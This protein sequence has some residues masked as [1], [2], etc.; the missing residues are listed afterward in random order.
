MTVG[1]MSCWWTNW[2]CLGSTNSF[3]LFCWGYSAYIW[4]IMFYQHGNWDNNPT[5]TNISK[6]YWLFCVL[7][8]ISWNNKPRWVD[9]INLDDKHPSPART[10]V[11]LLLLRLPLFGTTPLGHSQGSMSIIVD[12]DALVASSPT[13]IHWEKS[14]FLLGRISFTVKQ[15]NK[16]GMALSFSNSSSE[17][18]ASM[19]A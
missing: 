18:A 6:C 12:V 14:T 9:G 19:A 5:F 1:A 7:F 15:R 10:I 17:M 3:F 4:L 16:S 2:R 11:C 8:H 13:P